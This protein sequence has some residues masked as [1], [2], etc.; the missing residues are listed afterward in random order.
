MHSMPSTQHHRFRPLDQVE[1]FEQLLRDSHLQPVVVFKHSPTCGISAQAYDEIERYLRDGA[2]ADVH[3]LDVRVSR[4]LSQA[5]ARQ[6]GV[7]HES[8]QLLLLVDGR[9]AWV[10][11][12]FRVRAEGLRAALDDVPVTVPE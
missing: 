1:Q 11:S 9:A 3:L 10:A 7:R 12:H 2:G 5:V 6:L 8:P 4:G